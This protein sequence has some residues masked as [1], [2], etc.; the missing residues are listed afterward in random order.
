MKLAQ[1]GV[2]VDRLADRGHGLGASVVGPDVD[3]EVVPPPG[4]RA[5]T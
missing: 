5:M 1:C 4:A 3:G 2:A